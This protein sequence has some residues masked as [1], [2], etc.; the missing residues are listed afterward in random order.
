MWS[1]GG[2]DSFERSVCIWFLSIFS[3]HSWR[4][5]E[6]YIIYIMRSG[7]NNNHIQ[8]SILVSSMRSDGDCRSMLPSGGVYLL[9]S[10]TAAFLLWLTPGCLIRPPPSGQAGEC[11]GSVP[12][13]DGAVPGAADPRPE[14]RLSAEAA[15]GGSGLHQGPNITALH[16]MFSV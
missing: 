3:I 4:D 6:Y 9:N 15:A 1:S 5:P 8:L 16:S 10:F 13:E 2:F 11:A 14:D 12:P 7:I